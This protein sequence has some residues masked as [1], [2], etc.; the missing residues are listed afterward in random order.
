M[1]FLKIFAISGLA[2]LLM[3]VLLSLVIFSKNMR[4]IRS[5]Q[6]EREAIEQQLAVGKK[7]VLTSGLLGT[8]TAVD[9][10]QQELSIQLNDNVIVTAKFFAVKEVL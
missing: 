7:V 2:V 9:E 4:S 3:V 10:Q 1:E 6:F 5:A 8:I